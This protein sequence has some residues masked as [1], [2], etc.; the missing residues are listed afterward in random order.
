MKRKDDKYIA[1][2][3]GKKRERERENKL[4]PIIYCGSLT[5]FHGRQSY[6]III[7]LWQRLDIKLV[8]F[9]YFIDQNW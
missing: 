1:R 5:V 9:S 4:I 8:F 3:E 6:V 7:S 2:I